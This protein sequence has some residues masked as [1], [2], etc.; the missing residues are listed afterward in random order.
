V[1]RH[2]HPVGPVVRLALQ[3]GDNGETM[4]AELTRERYQELELHEGEQVHVKPKKLQVFLDY[5]I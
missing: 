1:V 5:S 3:R 4:E 2:I